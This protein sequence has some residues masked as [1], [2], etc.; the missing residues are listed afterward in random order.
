MSKKGKDPTAQRFGGEFG[1]YR[2]PGTQGVTLSTFKTLVWTSNIGGLLLVVLALELLFV[3]QRF[4][5]GLLALVLG[6]AVALFPS[7]YE[8]VGMNEEDD[9][10]ASDA[11]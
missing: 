10:E 3:Q 1:P 11:S 4:N 5:W 6:V 7:N 2:K 8:I 9:G